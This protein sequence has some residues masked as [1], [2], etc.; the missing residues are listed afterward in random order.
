VE[1]GRAP[2]PGHPLEPPLED[3]DLKRD[4]GIRQV[5]P[6]LITQHRCKESREVLGRKPQS[7]IPYDTIV[8]FNVDAK[9]E[10]SA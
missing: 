6:V 2:P 5:I 1:G 4:N 7:V 10:Y 3:G 8:E 9:A